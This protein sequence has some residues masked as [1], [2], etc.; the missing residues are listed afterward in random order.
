MT[1][2][3]L[4]FRRNIRKCD[5]MNNAESELRDIYLKAVKLHCLN[6]NGKQSQSLDPTEVSTISEFA[7]NSGLTQV[8]LFS[9]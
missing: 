5:T 3:V 1:N 7:F 8:V 4:I 9:K 6:V 2:L